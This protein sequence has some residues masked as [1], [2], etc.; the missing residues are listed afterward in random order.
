MCRSL[1]LSAEC[2]TVVARHHLQ[3]V[4][5]L[6]GRQARVAAQ[7]VNNAVVFHRMLGHQVLKWPKKQIIAYAQKS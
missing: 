5:I 4:G 7:V 2:A 1:Q 3:L 6:E